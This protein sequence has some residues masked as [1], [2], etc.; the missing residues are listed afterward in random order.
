ESSEVD[1]VALVRHEQELLGEIY[2]EQQIGCRMELPPH[3]TVR[4]N[5]SLASVLVSNL[6]RNAYI[7]SEPQAEVE[8]VCRVGELEISN[9]GSEP[10]DAKR[11]FER[12]YRHAKREGSTGLG[13]AL[14]KAICNH[15]Q[16]DI[17]Y[18]F[19]RQWH[20]FRLRF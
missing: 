12:F 16:I 6:L 8:V 4:M 14:V 18:R 1:L 15:Y 7:H 10:L 2:E 5:E 17:A 20:C 19:E 13:L 9:T 3:F 11:I